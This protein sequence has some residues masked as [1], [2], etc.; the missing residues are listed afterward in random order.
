MVGCCIRG[1][2]HAWVHLQVDSSGSGSQSR[3][4]NPAILARAQAANNLASMGVA[5]MLLGSPPPAPAP[6]HSLM[7]MPAAGMYMAP[8]A[9][10]LAMSPGPAM[11]AGPSLHH[12]YGLA[13]HMQQQVGLVPCLCASA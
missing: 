7:S 12:D 2:C 9:V 8:P 10:P 3:A 4:V 5:S 11:L 6:L 1:H 13:L